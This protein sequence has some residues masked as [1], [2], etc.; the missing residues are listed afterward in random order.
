MTQLEKEMPT[1]RMI[2]WAFFALG[3]NSLVINLVL[4]INCL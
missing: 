4:A 2:E 3:K 1:Y